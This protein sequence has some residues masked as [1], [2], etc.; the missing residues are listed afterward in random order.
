[1]QYPKQTIIYIY[2]KISFQGIKMLNPSLN[3]L[4]LIAKSIGIKDYKS[5]SEDELINILTEPKIE[6]IRK[7]N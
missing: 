3:E 2:K 6:E 5:K 1:M 4:N 7:K